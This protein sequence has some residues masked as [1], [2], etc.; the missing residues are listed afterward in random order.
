MDTGTASRPRRKVGRPARIDRAAIARVVATLAPEDL[1]VR[2]VADELGVSVAALYHH[3]SGREELMLL[4]AEQSAAK[5]PLP[6]DRDQHWAV[7]LFEWA[8]YARRA[9]VAQPALLGQF[10]E[11]GIGL[12]KMVEHIDVALGLCVRQGFTEQEALDAYYLISGF[13]LGAAIKEIRS[14]MMLSTGR[15]LEAEYR[16]VL[17]DVPA[18]RLVHLRRMVETSIS[19]AA[20]SAETEFVEEVTTALAGI[21]V[22]RGDDWEQVVRLVRDFA[23]A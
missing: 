21:A 7:W 14:K 13:A 5:I 11:G 2:S 15:T 20:D 3:V 6:E 16:R 8:D 9:F 22:R 1:S 17:L 18:D 19:D 23:G 10:T 12:D 4:A